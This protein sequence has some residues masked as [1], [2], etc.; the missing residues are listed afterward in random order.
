MKGLRV[1]KNIKELILKVFGT[2]Y[3]QK[4][5]PEEV[6]Q[7]IFVTKSTFHVKQMTTE[8]V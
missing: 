1:T 2:S 6:T 7:E 4:Q 8:K 3:T 5:F